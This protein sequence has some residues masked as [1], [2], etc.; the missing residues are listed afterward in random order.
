MVTWFRA[1]LEYH[2]PIPPVE[3]FIT[4]TFVRVGLEVLASPFSS[5]NL[6]PPPLLV[7]VLLIMVRFVRV[8][9][10]PSP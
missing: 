5:A 2:N 10:E 9:L 8:G 4:V 1:G 7:D 6:I 3:L